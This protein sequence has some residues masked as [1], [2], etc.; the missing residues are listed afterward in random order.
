MGWS[1]AGGIFDPICTAMVEGVE[2]KAVTEEW[3]TKTLTALIA[4]LQDGD[5]DT[6]DESLTDFAEHPFIV[7][8]FAAQGV[9]VQ[10]WMLRS[11]EDDAED[12]RTCGDCAEGRC[13]GGEPDDCGCDRHAASQEDAGE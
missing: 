2:S 8:A 5:W 12:D 6:E 1:S 7:A 3:A 13:H 9:E 11:A 10:D 4:S